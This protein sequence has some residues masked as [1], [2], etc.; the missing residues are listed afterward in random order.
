MFEFKFFHSMEVRYGDLDPQ[1]HLN[2]AKY[3]TYFEQARVHYFT[4]LGLF[5]KDQSFMDIGVIIADIHIQ[6]RAPVFWGAH[7][8][9]GVRA[10]KIANR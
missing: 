8:K 7:V 5:S 1:G 6:Y 4:H 10:A 2:N 3:L 9:V